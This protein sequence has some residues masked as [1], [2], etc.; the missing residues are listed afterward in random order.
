[1]LSFNQF[2]FSPNQDFQPTKPTKDFWLYTKKNNSNFA[3]IH[4]PG[5][6]ANVGYSVQI[7]AFLGILLLEG[8]PT[9][10]GV[11]QGVMWQGILGAIFVDIA[12]A[13]LSH[14]WHNKICLYENELVIAKT[15]V[16]QESYRRKINSA[17]SKTYFFYLLILF[18]GFL[19][20]YLFFNAYITWD[21]V[22]MVVLVCYV[23]GSV[24][25]I[26]FTGYFFFTSRF[27][28]KI[29]SE[30]S[31]FINSNGQKNKISGF[32]EQPIQTDGNSLLETKSGNH[33]IFMKN[34]IFYFKTWGIL[35][36]NEL[37]AL[38]GVQQTQIAQSI[39]AREGL[40]HQLLI[41]NAAI[42]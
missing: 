19:K 25:H 29:Q 30:Y 20:F 3:G 34:N 40:G 8:L 14:L 32:L 22:T 27:N 36:D 35:N 24:L 5:L 31:D 28:Y 41:L 7:A 39:V 15:I 2:D 10:Y 38:I 11:D 33:S 17:K 9:Y 42:N 12:F 16:L 18:S 6:F 21:S 13:I 1:M 23:L 4:L 37:S 26:F